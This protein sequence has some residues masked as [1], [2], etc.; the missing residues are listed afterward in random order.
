MNSSSLRL[1]YAKISTIAYFGVGA[2]GSGNLQKK[3]ANGTPTVGWAGWT[4]SKMTSIISAAHANRTRVVLTVQAFAWNSTGLARQ[5]ALLG[6]S[7]A[8]LNLARQIAAAVRDRGADGVNLDFEPLASTYGDEFTA[9]VR[10]IRTELN[11]IHA[12][13]QITFDTTGSIG[14]YPLEGAT[15]PGGAD[16]IFVMGYDYRTAGSSPVGS[17]APISRTGYDIRDTIVAYTKRVSPSKIILGV[18]YYGRAWSTSSSTIHASNT[19]GTKTGA[20]SSVNYSTA[21]EYL[22]RYGRKYDSVEQVAWTAYQRENCTTTY[23]CVDLVAPAVR[24]R[25]DGPEREVR[26]RQQLQPARC[27]HLGARL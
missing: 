4:S 15:A 6:S 24:G 25:C 16:A 19:S 12:G 22:A 23:G 2:D 11:R 9:L 27:G 20:S 26:P 5:K 14:S 3:N 17:I 21:V 1:D 18:P 10:T 7:T 8:R 13:Y